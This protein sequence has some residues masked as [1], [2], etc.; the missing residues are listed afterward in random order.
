MSSGV[1]QLP[2][3][4]NER[5]RSFRMR[6]TVCNV[7]MAYGMCA[8]HALVIG[9]GPTRAYGGKGRFRFVVAAEQI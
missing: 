2:G 6:Y 4:R 8:E 3:V 9:F 1:S 7:C 5:A